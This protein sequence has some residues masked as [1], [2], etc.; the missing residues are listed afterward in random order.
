MSYYNEREKIDI[1]DAEVMRLDMMVSAM[2]ELM[3]DKGFTREQLNAKLDKVREQRITLDPNKST[4]VC[5]KCGKLIGESSKNPFGA[6]CLYCG[7]EMTIYPGDS[8]E[9]NKDSNPDSDNSSSEFDDLDQ[10]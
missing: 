10:F 7:N 8:I 5:S 6:K 3:L 2:W 4:I 1:S 9:F